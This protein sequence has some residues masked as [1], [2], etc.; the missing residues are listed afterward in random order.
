MTDLKLIAWPGCN[1]GGEFITT[2]N[3]FLAPMAFYRG[4]KGHLLLHENRGMNTE[5]CINPGLHPINLVET[6]LV[7]NQMENLLFLISL[8]KE[9][10]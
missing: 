8:L 3:V 5:A 2:D 6:D 1:I 4:G 10:R 9:S 7:L